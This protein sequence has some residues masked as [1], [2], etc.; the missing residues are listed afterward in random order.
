MDSELEAKLEAGGKLAVL[1]L[2]RVSLRAR[3]AQCNFK[4]SFRVISLASLH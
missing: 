2:V 4:F 1:L 3:A